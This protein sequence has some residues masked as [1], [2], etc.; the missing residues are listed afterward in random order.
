MKY[1]GLDGIKKMLQKRENIWMIVL[2]GILFM[3]VAIPSNSRGNDTGK[4]DGSKQKVQNT[5]S[6][7]EE[8]EALEQQL[9]ELLKNIAG[10]GKV[11]VMITYKTRGE[12]AVEK[13]VEKENRV[14]EK[15]GKDEQMK[16]STVFAGEEPFVYKEYEPEIQGVVVIAQG[17]DNALVKKEI[18]EAIKALFAIEPH[19]IKIIKGVEE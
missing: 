7:G 5:V 12:K 19:K 9:E 4:K 11:Q 15:N 10:A 2:M 1:K 6:Y 8:K 17:A 13:D 14:D 18:L 16:E 3:V